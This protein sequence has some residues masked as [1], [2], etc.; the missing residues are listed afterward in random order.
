VLVVVPLCSKC[1]M[2]LTFENFF[3][4]ICLCECVDANVLMRICYIG[5]VLTINV[6]Q[7]PCVAIVAHGHTRVTVLTAHILQC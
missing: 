1:T 4:R 6:L 5:P 3:M 7:S 2:A